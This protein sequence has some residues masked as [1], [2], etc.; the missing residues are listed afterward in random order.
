MPRLPYL[1]ASVL[2]FAAASIPAAAAAAAPVRP[3]LPSAEP[4][5]CPRPDYPAEAKSRGEQGITTLGML[6]GTDGAVRRIEVLGPSGSAVLDTAAQESM[7]RCRFKPALLHGQPVERWHLSSYV[8]ERENEHPIVQINRLLDLAVEH[9]RPAAQFALYNMLNRQLARTKEGQRA[10]GIA[11]MTVLLRQA[12]EG[13]HCLSRHLLGE[14]YE[15][16]R[17]VKQDLRQ[18]RD[19]YEQAAACGNPVA[20]DR[21]AYLP[22]SR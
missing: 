20:A 4:G 11:Y 12:A 21:L 16:G 22:A 15:E 8:W 6:V 7:A 5:N 18:A 3:D 2:L 14:L 10:P 19:W 13:G 9:G 17:L 1:L